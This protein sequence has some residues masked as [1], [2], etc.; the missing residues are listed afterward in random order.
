MLPEFAYWSASEAA[1]SLL[2]QNEEA[3]TVLDGSI[4]RA[5]KI[6]KTSKFGRAVHTLH[7]SDAS[8]GRTSNSPS[9]PRPN[10]HRKQHADVFCG[11]LP[12]GTDHQSRI[13]PV[14]ADWLIKENKSC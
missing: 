12:F 2:Q 8:P 5:P 6:T 1:L 4:G 9:S 7:K 3:G 14:V 11:S 13:L 10:N